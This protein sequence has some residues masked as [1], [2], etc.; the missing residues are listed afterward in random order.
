ME[1]TVEHTSR[2]Q[3]SIKAVV[4]MQLQEDMYWEL[5]MRKG[6]ITL[7]SLVAMQLLDCMSHLDGHG[8]NIR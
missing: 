8:L 2:G 5:H 6:S 3:H 7:H 4:E 1:T